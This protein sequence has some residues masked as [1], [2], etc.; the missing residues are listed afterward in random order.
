MPHNFDSWK[1]FLDVFLSMTLLVALSPLIL[2][3]ALAVRIK[4][5]SPVLFLQERAGRAGAPFKI[6]KFRSMPSTEQKRDEFRSG[7]A[8]R[9]I[10]TLG[11]DE[12][13]QLWN[14][15]RGEM[16][17][18]GPR[19]LFVRYVDRYSTFERRRLEVRPGITGWAQVNGRNDLEWERQFALDVWYV[20]NRSF[21]LDALI[22]LRT[23]GVLL[24]PRAHRERRE[25]PEFT[26]SDPRTSAEAEQA[27]KR[28]SMGI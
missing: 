26:G 10:R 8:M 20:D 2:L 24:S 1:R 27:V 3:T 14:V 11:L 18:I 23:I 22:F 21:K 25:R 9:A 4:L 19:P 12:L 16:S 7:L 15:L 6:I 28:N 5:G 17:L 13:P